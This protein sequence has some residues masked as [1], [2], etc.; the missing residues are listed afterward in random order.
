MEI[1]LREC[2]TFHTALLA[3]SIRPLRHFVSIH[4]QPDVTLQRSE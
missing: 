2:Y 3:L 4:L 1:Q